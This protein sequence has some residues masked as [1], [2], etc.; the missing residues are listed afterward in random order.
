MGNMNEL[1]K[2]DEQ[3]KYFI[4]LKQKKIE[5]CKLDILK[6]QKICPHNNLEYIHGSNTGN[7]DPTQD[8]YW[9]E[10]RCNICKKHWTE[11]DD[12]INIPDHAI[13]IKQYFK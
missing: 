4:E 11:Y 1:T 6:L 8:I 3:I 7:Y 12:E 5:D 9:V 13:K 10:Y 2:T